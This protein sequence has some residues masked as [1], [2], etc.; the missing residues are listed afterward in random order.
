MLRNII[1]KLFEYTGLGKKELENSEQKARE[2]VAKAQDECIRIR[3]DA[4]EEAKKIVS[5]TIEIEKR[6]SKRERFL[7]EQEEQ[8]KKGRQS[9]EN[10]KKQIE[11]TKQE[12][13][14]KRDSVL[15]KLEKIAQLSKDDARVLLLKAWEDKL[16]TEIASKIRASEEEIKEKSNQRAKEIIVDAMRFGAS[17]YVA[18]Y[19][20]TVVNLPNDDFKGRIIGKDGRNIRAFEL[21]SGVD[22]DLEEESVIR[23]SSFDGI[24]REVAKVSLERLIK[25][26]R[27]QPQRIEEIIEKAKADIDKIIFKTGEEILHR[28]KIYN[29]PPE[30][31][32]ILGKYKYKY[33]SGQNMIVHAI[34]QTKIAFALANELGADVNTVKTACIF[35]N[36]GK[37]IDD[38]EGSYL[39]LG[40]ELLKKYKISQKVINAIYE[41]VNGNFSSLESSI[42]NIASKISDNRPNSKREGLD[43]YFERIKA[44]EDIA[45]THKGVDRAYALQAGREL[46]V[47]VKPEELSDDDTMILASKIREDLEKKMDSFPGQIKISLIRQVRSESLAKI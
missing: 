27:I 20:L 38:K 22:L 16:K 3:K 34:E 30:L 11:V 44:V 25:D 24:R 33:I 41:S 43:V 10:S 36:I 8:I 1:I 4:E 31:T 9:L 32:R 17:D 23:I 7:D 39:Q 12:F 21:A 29:I 18:E 37:V 46:R 47:I 6:I 2:I 35:Q 45:C 40:I 19:T 26:G 5:N 13:E 15:S 28:V 42:V 14:E